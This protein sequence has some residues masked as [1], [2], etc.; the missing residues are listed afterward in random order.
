MLALFHQQL[1][2]C[3]TQFIDK[4][5]LLAPTLILGILQYWPITNSSKE[6]LFL[7]E[8]EEILEL[9]QP[10]QFQL[11][12]DPLFRQIAKSIASPHFQV[13]DRCCCF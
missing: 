12:I 7:N 4:D 3:V 13:C 1:A 5:P 9:T 11:V 6:V 10:D 8:L 2:Y